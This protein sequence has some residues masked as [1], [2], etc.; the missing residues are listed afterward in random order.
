VQELRCYALQEVRA[1]AAAA[2]A[3]MQ[4]PQKTQQQQMAAAVPSVPHPQQLIPQG[5]LACLQLLLLPALPLLRQP[6]HQH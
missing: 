4:L 3:A 5:S 1:A 2:A 6:Y